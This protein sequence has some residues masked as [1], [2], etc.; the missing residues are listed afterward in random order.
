MNGILDT[1]TYTILFILATYF[2]A[3]TVVEWMIP[4]GNYPWGYPITAILTLASTFVIHHTTRN[5]E[6]ENT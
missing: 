4:S 1:L 2:T 3:I 5:T 6:K